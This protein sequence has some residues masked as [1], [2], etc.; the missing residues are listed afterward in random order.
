MRAIKYSAFLII[1][2]LLQG[3]NIQAQ[4]LPQPSPKASVMQQV[5]LT[6]I[7]IDYHS[8]GVKN[9]VIFGSLVPWNE[10][11]R[12]GANHATVITF[13]K[14]VKVDGNELEAG[15]YSLFTVPRPNEW[16]VIFNKETELW[17]TGNYDK[18]K[19]A[20]R[21]N[22]KPEECPKRERMAFLITDFSMTMADVSLEWEETRISFDVSVK[23]D[24]HAMANIEQTLESLPGKYANAA[25]YTLRAGMHHDKGLEW[26]DQAI[27][28]EEDWYFYWVKAELLHEKGEHKKAYEAMTKA[29][30]L[31]KEADSF[32]Y[33]D[34]VKKALSE[35]PKG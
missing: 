14:D 10:V 24:E 21:I 31:G 8:P 25:R 11:W 9:R 15:S 6:D 3:A 19:D 30:K 29:N 28:L 1:A 13:S 23:T 17:G 32:F 16:T 4:D 7:T 22:V 35:W 27:E 12:T 33:Q 20:L 5:G 26:V 34:K 18:G 2:V